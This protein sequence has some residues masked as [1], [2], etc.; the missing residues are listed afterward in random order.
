VD[1]LIVSRNSARA[2]E[3]ISKLAPVKRVLALGDTKATF[4]IEGPVQVDVRAVER[5]SYGAALAY[6]TGSKDHNVHLRTMGK[7]RG[8]K[9]NEY[10]VFEGTRKLGGHEREGRRAGR[11]IRSDLVARRC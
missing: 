9:I 2:L 8:W 10:G 11:P 5:S 1:I 4:I 7:D 6:F 3:K